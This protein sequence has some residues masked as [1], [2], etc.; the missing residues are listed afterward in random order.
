MALHKTEATCID[1]DHVATDCHAQEAKRRHELF[2]SILLDL[3]ANPSDHL[4]LYEISHIRQS[5]YQMK[6]IS[7]NL[8]AKAFA[9]GARDAH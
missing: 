4:L 1:G 5:S 9:S 7:E 6:L 3:P 8:F 2:S